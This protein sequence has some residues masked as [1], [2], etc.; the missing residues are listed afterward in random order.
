MT[1]NREL[2]RSFFLTRVYKVIHTRTHKNNTLLKTCIS[3]MLY[4][5]LKSRI[6]L[7]TSIFLSSNSQPTTSSWHIFSYSFLLMCCLLIIIVSFR[8]VTIQWEHGLS[9]GTLQERWL[10][11]YFGYWTYTQQS[12]CVWYQKIY[13][14]VS[15]VV[16]CTVIGYTL[17]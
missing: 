4:N 16:S 8:R 3:L 17:E 14:R 9:N 5:Y 13:F 6:F 12:F 10:E 7:R 11:L 1:F 15:L 2:F